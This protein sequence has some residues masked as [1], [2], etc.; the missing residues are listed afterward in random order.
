MNQPDIADIIAGALQTS[1]AHAYELMRAALAASADASLASKD[2]EI[3][4][5]REDAERYQFIRWYQ[6]QDTPQ[7]KLRDILLS[8]HR[9]AHERGALRPSAEE[10]ETALDEAIAARKK[11]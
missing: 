10:Y 8:A 9:R 7:G 6:D 1:R 11:G 2:A 4:G 3:A 5:L